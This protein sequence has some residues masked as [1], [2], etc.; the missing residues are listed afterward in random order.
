MLLSSH[1][2][3]GGL[4][5]CSNNYLL[6]LPLQLQ[7]FVAADFSPLS[8]KSKKRKNSDRSCFP[9]LLSCRSENF[10][11]F[12]QSELETDTV[13][14]LAQDHLDNRLY[15]YLAL[16]VLAVLLGFLQAAFFFFIANRASAVLHNIALHSLLQAPLSFF[17]IN[18]PGEMDGGMDGMGGGEQVDGWVCL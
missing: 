13:F 14:G 8:I 9:F 3:F 17:R 18:T 15:I 2:Y 7:N 1:P 16:V 4:N 10:Q 6:A 11:N 12:N 5:H